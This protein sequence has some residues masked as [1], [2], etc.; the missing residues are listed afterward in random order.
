MKKLIYIPMTVG[1]LGFGGIVLAN[2]DTAEEQTGTTSPE[3]AV[4]QV[5]EGS[6]D[7]AERLSFEEVSAKAL[8]VV[9]GMVTDVE[10]DSDDGRRHYDIEIKDGEFEYELEL[11]AYSGEVLKQE[12][13][14]DDDDFNRS[15]AASQNSSENAAKGSQP[16]I[17]ADEAAQAALATVSGTVEE[18]ELDR[19]NGVTYYEVEIEDGR[20]DHEI[21][22]NAQDGTILKTETDRD[23]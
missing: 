4:V 14:A 16:L 2:T 6:A 7:S 23:D 5:E 8:K 17:S 10:L 11:D 9:N 1:I 13:D 22:V 21:H 12:K 19:D 20:V 15:A 3:P 18:V